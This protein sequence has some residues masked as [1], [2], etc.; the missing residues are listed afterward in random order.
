MDNAELASNSSYNSDSLQ[1]S[2]SGLSL[3][4][5]E[6]TELLHLVN[7]SKHPEPHSGTPLVPRVV[8]KSEGDVNDQI[9]HSLGLATS[10]R[11]QELVKRNQEL[12][13]ELIKANKQI[14]RL[15]NCHNSLQVEKEVQGLWTTN[16]KLREWNTKLQREKHDLEMECKGLKI[17]LAELETKSQVN[18]GLVASLKEKV[19]QHYV[20]WQQELKQSAN[21][22]L[23]VSDLTVQ[24]KEA[25][26]LKFWYKTQFNQW[27]NTKSELQ[28]CQIQVEHLKADNSKLQLK[29]TECKS[30]LDNAQLEALKEKSQL[31]QKLEKFNLEFVPIEPIISLTPCQNCCQNPSEEMLT[32]LKTQLSIKNLDVT[33]LIEEN[34]TITSK[35]IVLQKVLQHKESEIE[36]LDLRRKESNLR[37]QQV[38]ES[39]QTK[40]QQIHQLKAQIAALQVELNGQKADKASVERQIEMLR[41]QFAQFKENYD[42]VGVLFCLGFS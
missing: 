4:Q 10:Q 18:K 3:Y 2:L 8:Q 29:L 6:Y 1:S 20:E 9:Q 21:L 15:V 11:V 28:S 5:D 42:L 19:S 23:V 17:S 39:E 41:S 31:L 26:R 36:G 16:M 14:N 32:G 13:T 34:S 40:E 24:L 33:R 7:P 35:C 22:K 27:Q 30:E 37:L 25:D 12:E 38:Q